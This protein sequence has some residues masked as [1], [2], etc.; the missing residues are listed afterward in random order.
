MSKQFQQHMFEDFTQ[1]Y[2]NVNRPKGI[3]GTGLGLS[4]VK[5]MLT[6]MGGTIDIQSELGEGTSVTVSIPVKYIGENKLKSGIYGE[7]VDDEFY[8]D[9]KILLTEDNEINSE[10]MLRILEGMCSNIV[11][12]E[13]GEKAV[14]AFLDSEENEYSLILMDIQMPVMDGYEATKRIRNSSRLDGKKVYIAAMTA[15]AFDEAKQKAKDAG[16]NSFLTKP[17]DPEKLKE[18][19]KEVSLKIKEER[20]DG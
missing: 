7:K 14:N 3:S 20:I 1:E 12:V 11:H 8:F 5:K 4:I 18:L 13:N 9:G 6:L 19:L 16:V 15:D 17:I 10:I 2:D